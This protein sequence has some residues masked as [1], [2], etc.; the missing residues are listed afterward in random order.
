MI[1]VTPISVLATYA[2]IGLPSIIA[3][4]ST[5]PWLLTQALGLTTIA[6]GIGASAATLG[7]VLRRRPLD[8]SSRAPVRS[9]DAQRR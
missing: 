5:Y 3:V 6:L 7:L 2:A 1:A 8:G 9:A 4:N